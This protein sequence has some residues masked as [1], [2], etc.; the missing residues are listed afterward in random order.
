LYFNYINKMHTVLCGSFE[1]R[2][3]L[4]CHRISFQGKSVEQLLEKNREEG[5]EIDGE[6]EIGG[7][8]PGCHN[9]WM[10]RRVAE[11][12]ICHCRPAHSA[13]A[14]GEDVEVDALAEVKRRPP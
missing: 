7:A 14:D 1:E 11:G 6:I 2:N 5:D 12:P 3:T 13:V 8:K 4:A 9:R 10:E